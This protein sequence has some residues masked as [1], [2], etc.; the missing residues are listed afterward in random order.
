MKEFNKLVRNKIP[1]VIQANGE[2]AHYHVIEDDDAYLDALLK[3]D[4][5]EGIE[6]AQDTNLEELADKLEV[7]YAIAKVCGYKPEQVEQ[8]RVEKAIKRGGFD[9][10]IFLE[11]TE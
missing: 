9:K 7:L 3:K 2:I 10:R 6:L 5:E 1:D 4:I 8:A 11:S